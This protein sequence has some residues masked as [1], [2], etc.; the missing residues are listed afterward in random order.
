MRELYHSFKYWIG[1]FVLT[2][3]IPGAIMSWLYPGGPMEIYNR[4]YFELQH[5]DNTPTKVYRLPSG[6]DFAH[7]TEFMTAIDALKHAKKGD[8]ITLVVDE[9]WGGA[10][11]ILFAVINTIKESKAEVI[12]TLNRFGFS[13]GSFI[14]AFGDYTYLPNNALL[15]FHTGSYLGEDGNR[16]KISI[17]DLSRSS[18]AGYIVYLLLMRHYEGYLTPAE[19]RRTDKGEDV[20]VTGREICDNVGRNAPI[21]FHLKDGCVLTG[22]RG[23]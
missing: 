15:G 20:F 2:I 19:R 6:F 11:N 21:L 17:D 14:L 3:G 7:A 13:C 10:D 1:V 23:L 4:A 22:K 16:H 18:L 12:I 9:N 8:I 5:L